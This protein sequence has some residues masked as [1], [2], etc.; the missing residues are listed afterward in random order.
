MVKRTLMMGICLVA[1]M[2]AM[3]LQSTTAEASPPGQPANW[4]RFYHYPYVYYPQN[5]QQPQTY[6]HMY[7]KYGQ[8]RQIP[9][10]NKDWHN[11]YPSK[12]PYHWGHHFIL[13]VF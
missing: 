13:D 5:F 2:V 10:Y 7:Y 9:V 11:F 1:C 8:E 4:G 6:D 3:G 12:R